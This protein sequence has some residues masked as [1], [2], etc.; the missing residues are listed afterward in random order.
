MRQF[1][2][3]VTHIMGLFS[4]EFANLVFNEPDLEVLEQL[5][6][7]QAT[8][9]V[10]QNDLTFKVRRANGE[11]FSARSG[12]FSAVYIGG[13]YARISLLRYSSTGRY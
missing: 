11:K 12:T 8:I 1:D 10:H 5:D 7:K 3:V 6:T 4:P 13:N 9:K 2:P